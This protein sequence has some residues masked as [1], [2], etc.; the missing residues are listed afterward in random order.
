[1]SVTKQMTRYPLDL[2]GKHP[3]NKVVNERV[4]V[5]TR[6]PVFK[7]SAGA[8]Y[9]DSV[10]IVHLGETLAKGVDYKATR[11]VEDAVILSNQDVAAY[12]KITDK[13]L[14][15]ELL[16]TYQAVGGEY[17][18]IHNTLVEILNDY[19][20][21]KRGVYF[22]DV[23]N[24]P[25]AF[26]PVRHLH[27]VYDIYGLTPISDPLNELVKLA[28]TRASR[29]DNKTLYR[30]H[31][32]E[33][34]LK[35]LEFI[36]KDLK[37][38]GALVEEVGKLKE[39]VTKLNVNTI[40]E[41]IDNVVATITAR[42]T[43]AEATVESL[44]ALTT[45]QT[46]KLSTLT[47]T[48]TT[49]SQ[50]IDAE[51]TQLKSDINVESTRE[52][53]G[54]GQFEKV[55]LHG[56]RLTLT[57]D[58]Q[59]A[60]NKTAI[61]ENKQKIAQL[62]QR[63][64]D[65]DNKENPAMAGVTRLT[66]ELETLKPLVASHT[67]TIAS[68]QTTLE[69]HGRR[70]T[71]NTHEI[72]VVKA[73]LE[74][75][76]QASRQAVDQA[77]IDM[78]RSQAQVKEALS[79]E[80]TEK[81]SGV[82]QRTGALIEQKAARV[83]AA[84]DEEIAKHTA[85]IEALTQKDADHDTQLT[86][87]KA[88]LEQ[89]FGD[90]TGSL[91]KQIAALS[92]QQNAQGE[93]ITKA[94]E[95]L[96]T[97]QGELGKTNAVLTE[98]TTK[99]VEDAEEARNTLKE[100][101]GKETDKKLEKLEE[102]IGTSISGKVSD[103]KEAL[104]Q[105]LTSHDTEIAQLKQ[106]AQTHTTQIETINQTLSDK[107]ADETG[108]IVKQLD[109][110]EV[111]QRNHATR[112]ST[113][114]SEI[115]EIKEMAT[116]NKT[117]LEAKI[118]EV[119]EAAEQAREQL[120]TQVMASVKDKLDESESKTNE[121]I[122]SRCDDVKK[123]LLQHLRTHDEKIE[124]LEAKDRSHDG[125][126]SQ[127]QETLETELASGTGRI[128]KQLDEIG[129]KLRQ[130]TSS[131][132]TNAETI[133]EV[134]E[135]LQNS[136]TKLQKA[137]D[138]AAEGNERA[139]TKVKE[140]ITEET[141]DKLHK[142]EKKLT[143]AIE[144]G[145]DGVNTPLV[146]RLNAHDELFKEL[147]SKD[148]HH[149]DKLAE[150]TTELTKKLGNGEDALPAQVSR[151]KEDQTTNATAIA[152]NAENIIKGDEAVKTALSAM[153]D[154][155]DTKHTRKESDLNEEI[156]R[157]ETES[158]ARDNAIGDKIT[159]LT[160]V[161]EETKKKFEDYWSKTEVMK[162]SA[163][164][165]YYPMGVSNT[166]PEDQRGYSGIRRT[167]GLTENNIDHT[168]RELF[169]GNTDGEMAN[170][171]V[172]GFNGE[173]TVKV[174]YYDSNGKFVGYKDILTSLHVEDKTPLEDAPLVNK[175]HLTRAIGEMKAQIDQEVS[176]LVTPVSQKAEQAHTLATSADTLARENK[177][178]LTTLT[179]KAKQQDTVI[180]NKV[181]RLGRNGTK[182]MATADYGKL[183]D[184]SGAILS[185][186]VAATPGFCILAF[187]VS[188]GLSTGKPITDLTTCPI[189]NE[190]AT[191]DEHTCYLA[192]IHLPKTTSP[193]YGWSG[194]NS[195]E[196]CLKQ[197]FAN[198]QNRD[199]LVKAVLDDIYMYQLQTKTAAYLTFTYE[200]GLG[201]TGLWVGTADVGEILRLCYQARKD[202]A[203]ADSLPRFYFDHNQ[204]SYY[205]RQA[206]KLYKRKDNSDNLLYG[207]RMRAVDG[208]VKGW[209]A[210][211]T[212][213]RAWN[214]EGPE[215]ITMTNAGSYNPMTL[216][217]ISN[218]GTCWV[219]KRGI[220]LPITGTVVYELTYTTSSPVPI[221]GLNFALVGGDRRLNFIPEYE[222]DE[223]PPGATE[224][225]GLYRHKLTT[226]YTFSEDTGI[227]EP[228]YLNMVLGDAG[229]TDQ[230]TVTDLCLTY[231]REGIYHYN[232]GE[233]DYPTAPKVDM[234]PILSKVQSEVRRYIA[235]QSKPANSDWN[236]DNFKAQPAA[237][238][239]SR[240]HV[241]ENNVLHAE[242]VILQRF[243]G[244]DTSVFAPAQVFQITTNQEW[245]VPK[246]LVGRKAE[247]TIRAKS[248]KEGD[249]IIHSAVRRTFVTLP[250]GM[251]NILAGELTS[252][253]KFLTVNVNTDYPDALTPRFS[254]PDG[255]INKIQDALLTITV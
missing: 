144:Q 241:D 148:S 20:I 178:S 128:P 228:V 231:Y 237:E 138:E 47:T 17:Q 57:D 206:D 113:N 22:N 54:R 71:N 249:D 19:K 176:T 38:V 203:S 79:E 86:E 65:V 135:D 107:L 152:K 120:K 204:L 77:V 182:P 131:I 157:V 162:V 244:G 254:V 211:N 160:K 74:N 15:G 212:E 83:K 46:S 151:L 133:A 248:R 85:A 92:E 227:F 251:I 134:K 166:T 169:V 125:T 226:T 164:L 115:A 137:I 27:S 218:H 111:K 51:I 161:D 6:S 179:E 172:L 9:T 97:L 90:S 40:N 58:P 240:V 214:E 122:E 104:E 153:L 1:M 239:W 217:D 29:I 225:E 223:P 118:T 184:E 14:V 5:D 88:Q 80:I 26:V 168:S 207:G 68:Y 99:I 181:F 143:E 11:M 84:V 250:E 87:V 89:K 3:D 102:T 236:L 209:Q 247:I 171:Q 101:I 130:H 30:L 230:R 234:G 252:F 53:V 43:T 33:E 109:A 208:V 28:R 222:V 64:T 44:K 196:A 141:D 62:S 188:E 7:L 255:G 110:I 233:D 200:K 93:K 187:K 66:T 69:D 95:D 224:E 183:F 235:E 42:L 23:V 116:S 75:A 32:L 238:D 96:T 13:T 175:A 41:R 221:K 136:K 126:L 98:K 34:T 154:E 24:L 139:H 35:D 55:G 246:T 197:G 189:V 205:L 49:F 45:E 191:L 186:Q 50:K 94:A 146:N 213:W 112:I 119:K 150:I 36:G 2:T 158:K 220:T 117:A 149:D 219:N 243:D 12:I 4:V 8:F 10:V 25:T 124:A 39:L 52:F 78:N 155:V 82:E 170:A 215:G 201:I 108:S 156:T 56:F 229:T 185:S 31:R 245:T 159:A 140:D 194:E 91:T 232:S 100:T 106:T 81:V 190:S 145:K 21:D 253:G 37:T 142:L 16:V 210:G 48:Y 63:I 18:N 180:L 103:A 76:K 198:Y 59:V 163:G 61:E 114:E 70:I 174:G 147:K 193:Y 123:P 242:G 199:K 72:G 73:D 202:T 216:M 167:V 67:Q 195:A 177:T 127:I 105:R 60:L 173:H 132:S 192:H 129:V 165:G 121:K